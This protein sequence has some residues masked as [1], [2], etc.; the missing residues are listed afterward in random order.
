MSESLD[1]GVTWRA[2]WLRV[3]SIYLRMN[4]KNIK[5]VYVKDD[6]LEVDGNQFKVDINDYTGNSER[7]IFLNAGNGRFTIEKDG[8]TTVRQFEINL[9][10]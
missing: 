10:S 4:F 2:Q 7:Y 5:E 1:P 3:L 9:L 8:K 6:G